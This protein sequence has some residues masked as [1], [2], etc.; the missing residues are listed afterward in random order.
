MSSIQ[1]GSSGQYVIVLQEGLNSLGANLSVD[2][3]FGPA[4]KAA[5]IAYQNAKGLSP[6][7]VVGPITGAAIYV[8]VQLANK[9]SLPVQPV[10]PAPPVSTTPVAAPSGMWAPSGKGQV[11]I[12]DMYH[13]DDI[14]NW[15]TLA[16]RA[17]AGIHKIATG[18][19]SPDPLFGERWPLF[20]QY[21]MRRG[22]YQWFE[23]EDGAAMFDYAWSLVLRA[24][25]A[26]QNDRIFALD[27]EPP[28]VEASYIPIIK[29]WGERC[30]AV[31]GRIPWFYSSKSALKELAA[32]GD[33]SFLKGWYDWEADP[34]DAVA[35]VEYP[36]SYVALHQL[37]EQSFEGM[38]GSEVDVNLFPGT[39]AELDLL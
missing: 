33:I 30:L 35:V 3:E 6:D 24:G 18:V 23:A 1:E 39:A 19:G 21:G 12:I 15:G 17:A 28:S 38:Q 4:T 26:K 9:I 25:G 32:L 11:T 29:A 10:D 2:G 7:G 31:S 5:V 36:F 37:A 14:T 20:A 8:D 22:F 34:S 13:E 16:A 27:F